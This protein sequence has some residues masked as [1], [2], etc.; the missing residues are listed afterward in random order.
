MEQGVS[1][2]FDIAGTEKFTGRF[3]YDEQ[4]DKASG[5]RQVS[6][7]GISVQSLTYGGNWWPGGTVAVDGETLGTMTYEGTTT[8][9]VS[10][11]ASEAWNQVNAIA[12]RGGEFPWVSGEIESNPDGSKTVTFT[13][14][15]KLYRNAS[16]PL[17]LIQGSKTIG[18]TAIPRSSAVT[19]QTTSMG[20]TMAIAIQRADA[21]YTHDL[22]WEFGGESGIIAQ[23][24]ATGA[25][26]EVPLRLA[27]LIPAAVSGTAKILCKTFSGG[28]ELGQSEAE[29]TLTVPNDERTRPKVTLEVN[30][31][32]ALPQKFAGLYVQGK[33][34]VN[35]AVG[36]SSEYSQVDKISTTAWGKTFEGQA[37][38]FEPP[39]TSG[40]LT[41]RTTVTDLRGYSTQKDVTIAVIPYSPPAVIPLGGA[42]RPSAARSDVDGKPKADGEY[43]RVEAGRSYSTVNGLNSCILKARWAESGTDSYSPWVTLLPAYGSDFYT[44]VAGA[45]F[46]K[47]D[48]YTVQLTAE[49]EITGEVSIFIQVPSSAVPLHLGEGGRNVGLGQYCDYSGPDRVDVGWKLYANRGIGLMKIYEGTGLA[50]GQGVLSGAPDAPVQMVEHYSLFLAIVGGYPV[51]CARSGSDIRGAGVDNDLNRIGLRLTW[52]GA[53]ITVTKSEN[54]MSALYALI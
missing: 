39:G 51:L 52:N 10:V 31:T 21:A 19:A 53:D 17:V 27:K 40:E 38:V 25:S 18:L 47:G 41:V 43:L 26:W 8:H 30:P 36:A 33:T 16:S 50:Q 3:F 42:S 44:G 34:N 32:S 9:S 12:G 7:T 49:D 15:V 48:G 29:V 23:G 22:S 37:V 11:G 13:V 1:G 46:E 14:D 20:S 28:T 35:A 24:A 6:I 54:S 2:Y 4:Y 5:K 45:G